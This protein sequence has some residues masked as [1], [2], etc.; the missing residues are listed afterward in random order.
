[1]FLM[2]EGNSHG[3]IQKKQISS[4]TSCRHLWLPAAMATDCERKPLMWP[5]LMPPAVSIIKSSLLGTGLPV[6]ATM[7]F[8][9]AFSSRN[10]VYKEALL[11][12]NLRITHNN[13]RMNT[14]YQTRRNANRSTS[15]CFPPFLADGGRH[16]RLFE[17]F[18]HFFLLRN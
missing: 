7:H 2:Y 11:L 15:L 14:I 6:S 18:A 16:I 13:L 12:N 4:M 9:F 5:L 10:L 1:M 8:A 17:I 3:R